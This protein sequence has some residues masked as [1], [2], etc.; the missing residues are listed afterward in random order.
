MN[1]HHQTLL[2]TWNWIRTNH[3]WSQHVS[4]RQLLLL[5]NWTFCIAIGL[6]GLPSTNGWVFPNRTKWRC[7]H[8][9]IQRHVSVAVGSVWSLLS[10]LESAGEEL[11]SWFCCALSWTP[12]RN[13][14]GVQLFFFPPFFLYNFWK[15][16]F[17]V[18][19]AVI[20]NS[21]LN[22]DT[23]KLVQSVLFIFVYLIWFFKKKTKKPHW[24][25]I[26]ILES[27][28]TDIVQLGF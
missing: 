1:L 28:L 11:S 26:V 8:C 22:W 25:Y 2:D 21:I 13:S 3:M 6:S 24:L 4:I 7:H 20:S 17:S 14:P 16:W 23:P 5:Q 27:E 10:G 12:L 9:S 19:K 15:T 18:P